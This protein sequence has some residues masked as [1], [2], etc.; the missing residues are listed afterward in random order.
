MLPVITVL[1]ILKMEVS[2]GGGVLKDSLTVL[3]HC[4]ILKSLA[5][6]SKHSTSNVL[7]KALNSF[8]KTPQ[9]RCLTG[10]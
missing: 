3:A 6:F 9:L 7:N 10:F 2:V 1:G 8:S 4:F 5:I